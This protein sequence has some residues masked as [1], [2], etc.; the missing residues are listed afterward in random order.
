LSARPEVVNGARALEALGRE[1]DACLR[2]VFDRSASGLVDQ[3][4]R[5]FDLCPDLSLG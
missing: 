4:L 1:H 2:S 3:A 5:I